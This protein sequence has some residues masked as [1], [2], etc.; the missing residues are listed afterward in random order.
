LEEDFNA[1]IDSYI[2]S[3]K[4]MGIAPRKVYNGVLN[5]RIPSETDRKIALIAESERISINTF[6]RNSIEKGL[7]AVH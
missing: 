2:E 1:A 4:E 7:E 5:I 3:C 6:I